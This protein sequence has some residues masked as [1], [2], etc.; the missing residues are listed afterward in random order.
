[1]QGRGAAQTGTE[2]PLR[3]GN[4]WRA[5]VG[6][7]VP[8]C[9]QGFYWLCTSKVVKMLNSVTSFTTIFRTL[10]EWIRCPP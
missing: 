4:A 5:T 8:Q 9:E 7:V 6:M 10:K 1:M 3:E 2:F